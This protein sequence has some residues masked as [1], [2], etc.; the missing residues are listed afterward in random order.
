MRNYPSHELGNEQ[1][2][3]IVT[4]TESGLSISGWYESG[5]SWSEDLPWEV[6]DDLRARLAAQEQD[7]TS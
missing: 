3:G 1:Y 7:P 4:A 6:I 2:G 5:T